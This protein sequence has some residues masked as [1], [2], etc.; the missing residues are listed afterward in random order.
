MQA[1]KIL[2]SKWG[3][4]GAIALLAAGVWYAFT[5]QGGTHTV[6]LD[7]RAWGGSGYDPWRT[8]RQSADGLAKTRWFPDRVAPNCLPD[9]LANQDSGIATG[10]AS[11]W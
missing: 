1:S 7:Q 11:G 9:P 5:H 4:P 8:W 6:S 10:A 2:Q 3:L